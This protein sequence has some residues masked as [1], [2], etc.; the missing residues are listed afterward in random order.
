MLI[1]RITVILVIPA[2]PAL[3]KGP[4]LEDNQEKNKKIH[5]QGLTKLRLNAPIGPPKM[6]YFME[7]LI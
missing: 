7:V 3:S 2:C 6:G 5:A 4:I 1:M